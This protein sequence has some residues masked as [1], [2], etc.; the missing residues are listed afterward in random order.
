MIELWFGIGILLFLFHHKRHFVVPLHKMGNWCLVVQHL[1]DFVKIDYDAS[2]PKTK[3]LKKEKFIVE[4]LKNV[5]AILFIWANMHPTCSIAFA[6]LS[7]FF[8]ILFFL[9]VSWFIG[10]L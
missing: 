10:Q 9:F 1:A 5:F 4:Y 8:F 7:F 2:P 3:L 6:I